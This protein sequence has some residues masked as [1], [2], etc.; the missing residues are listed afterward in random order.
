MVSY[1]FCLPPVAVFPWRHLLSS[2]GND[3][4]RVCHRQR[5]ALELLRWQ[6]IPPSL[7]GDDKRCLHGNT[8]T[9]GKQ[10][11]YDT[12]NLL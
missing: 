8:A 6:T 9:R 5:P 3:G 1:E 2:P 11:S 10:K 4:G 7:P 12:I